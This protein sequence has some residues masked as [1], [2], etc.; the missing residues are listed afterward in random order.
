LLQLASKRVVLS[1]LA[2]AWKTLALTSISAMKKAGAMA[3]LIRED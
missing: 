1:G 2:R 3:G